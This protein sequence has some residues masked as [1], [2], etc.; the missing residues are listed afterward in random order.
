MNSDAASE[1]RATKKFEAMMTEKM[2]PV[3]TSLSEVETAEW[4]QRR[5]CRRRGRRW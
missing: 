2:Q 1:E 5:I 4:L 3:A